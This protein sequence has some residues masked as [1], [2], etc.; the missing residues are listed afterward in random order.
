MDLADY[1][2]SEYPATVWRWIAWHN[3]TTPDLKKEVRQVSMMCK[4]KN[5]LAHQPRRPLVTH[6]PNTL[7]KGFTA[8][9]APKAHRKFGKGF[10]GRA[11]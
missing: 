2:E 11:E 4:E 7:E 10:G 1:L 5:L 3:T 9:K 8:L 6:V